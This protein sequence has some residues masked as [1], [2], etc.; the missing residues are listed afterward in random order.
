MVCD[1][2]EQYRNRACEKAHPWLRALD[3]LAEMTHRCVESDTIKYPTAVSTWRRPASGYEQA[4][5]G[6]YALIHLLHELGEA[7]AAKQ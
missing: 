3:L 1:R 5:P 6:V 4:V 7:K 2:D